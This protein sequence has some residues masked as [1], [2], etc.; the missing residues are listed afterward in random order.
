MMFRHL[1]QWCVITCLCVSCTTTQNFVS[2]ENQNW[3]QIPSPPD[4]ELSYEVFL[5]GDAGGID[6]PS[7][8]MDQLEMQ[9][10]AAG[11]N[12]AVV[13][14]GDNVYC[15]GLPDSAS[16]DRSKAEQRL[17]A[18][19]KPLESFEGRILFVPGNHDWNHSK[20]GGREALARQEKFVQDYLDRGNTFRPDNGFP[21]PEEIKLTDHLT[22]IAIDTEW[23]LTKHDRG[24]GDGGNYHIEEEGDFLLALHEVIQDNDDE[25]VLVVGHHPMFSNGEHSGHF[26]LKT[27][28][29][30]LTE[31]LP[32]AY[33]PL[34]LLGSLGPLYIRYAGSRQDLAHRK[35]RALRT[36]LQRAFGEHES[37]I[38]AAG[39]EHNL[40]YFKGPLHD[41]IVSGSGS[42]PSYVSKGGKAS[43]TSRNPGY[44]T[45]RYYKD[46]SVWI[47]MWAVDNE[48]P[49]GTIIFRKEISGPSREAVDP[50][51][52][53]APPSSYP[54]YSDST[55][56]IAANPDYQ[57][58]AVYEFFLGRQNRELWGIPVEVPYLDMGRD[59]GGGLTPLKRGGGM[60]TFSLRLQGEDGYQYSLRSV[61][62][63]PSVSIPEFLRETVA[64]EVVQ[65]QIASIHPY[66]AYIIPKLA[67]AAGIFYT[68]P[69]LVYVPD[70]P[71]LGVYRDVFGGQLMMFELRPDDDMSAFENFGRSEKVVSA[72]KFYEEITEDNDNRPDVE[73]FVR[74]RLF[75]MLL[76]DWDRHRLQW[77]WAEFEDP[78]GKGS[79]YKP[80]PRD[81]D[82]A[83]N[84]FNGLLPSIMRIGIDPKFQEFDYDFGYIKGLTRNGLWQDRRLTAQVEKQTWLRIAE[85]LKSRITDDVIEEAI[86]DWPQ[87]IIDYHGDEVVAKLKAR[88]DILPQAA[89]EYYYVLAKY[90]DF[91]GTHKHERFE[92]TRID[93]NETRLVVLKTSKKGEVRDTLYT[94]T[95]FYNETNEIR[96]FGMDGND[97]FIIS[98][99]AST[100]I[101]IRAIG[102]E[103]EDTFI[104]QSRNP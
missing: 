42:R 96:L 69:R 65:D 23:W 37:L 38:Y 56:V 85:D 92:V 22:L 80:I 82:W 94:R 5:I 44:S 41:Y 74:A 32:W 55:F 50:Q 67:D 103:G 20:E 61:D 39:H 79:I 104:D 90:I 87:P 40:Q 8:V 21:G 72:D 100:G 101:R 83:F 29:F 2:K 18:Q 46:G 62:K 58:N 30:P 1:F 28:I 19:L 97:E 53:D 17:L 77:R 75:D 43:F 6:G 68:Q 86:L 12:A 36:G 78:D 91:V 48:N 52:P 51:L 25:H 13:F 27:H 35:Y 84:R 98:G 33:V 88:R 73:A 81:R 3:E 95:F 99:F 54:D 15:C 57:A 89:A 7:V 9:L 4:S 63:D 60:Q 16:V 11:K 49:E 71:R 59:G 70:D 76:S 26:P 64:T 34:P 31:F 66:G 45:V 93:E 47:T 24:E 10:K 14:L 102:G